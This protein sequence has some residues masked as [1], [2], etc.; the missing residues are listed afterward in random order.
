MKC[1]LGVIDVMSSE[2]RK[3]AHRNNFAPIMAGIINGARVD[4]LSERICHD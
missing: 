3:R 1:D 4:T 2:N